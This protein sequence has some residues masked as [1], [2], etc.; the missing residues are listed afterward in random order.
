MLLRRTTGWALVTASV[1]ASPRALAANLDAQPMAGQKLRVDGMLS[2][3]RGR[4]TELGE[5]VQGRPGKGL[6]ASGMVGYD[7]RHV[8]VAMK[9]RDANL[10]RTKDAGKSEDHA[11]LLLSI[12]TGRGHATYAVDLFPGEPGRLPGAVKMAGRAVQGA[13]LVEAPAAG[14]FVFEAQ[15][16]WSAFPEAKTV[17]VGL[18]GALR[19]TDA[20]ASGRVTAVVATS[21]A[22]G[23]RSLPPLPLE[24]EQALEATLVQGKGLSAKPAKEL[25]GNV[26]GDAMLERVALY[27]G[28]LTIVGP[29]YRGGKQFYFSD[30]GVRN[31]SMVPRFELHDF[32]GD[33]RDEIVLQKRVG[34]SEQYREILQI[35]KVGTDDAPFV[36]FTH[37]TGIKTTDEQITNVVKIKKQGK[38]TV[39]KISQGQVEGV[40][41]ATY[42]ELKP[43]EYESALL[44]WD[45][46]KSRTFGWDKDAIRKLDEESWE[47]KLGPPGAG[48]K[49]GPG[50]PMGPPKP[51]PPRPPSADEL[52]DRVYAL[53]KKDR[54]VRGGKP[55]F[56]FVT[57]VVG[58]RQNERVLVHGKDIVAFGAGFKGGTSYTFITVGVNEPGDIVD[59]TARDLTGDGKAEVVVRGIVRAKASEELGGMEVQRYA[60][61]V[62]KVTDTGLRRIFG[63]ETGRS[64]DG[65]RVLGAVAF[66]PSAAGLAIELRPA[67]AVGWTQKTYPFPTDTTAAGGLEPLL[68]PWGSERARRYRFDGNGYVA[69]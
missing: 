30:L 1:I 66:Q 54:G 52:L 3:W 35:F 32:D 60:L 68:L 27:D 2:E 58:D 42:D 38:R 63:A 15:I 33:G 29:R 21:R 22:A 44:P 55:S 25:V 40:D 31:A 39:I 49:P 13:K 41:P 50:A 6:S 56:D 5:T 28:H 10:M 62:Y 12:P 8:Y 65:N 26:A 16:P 14:G 61:L 47:P 53:Y 23:G 19:Y 37:E 24:S 7:D 43:G 69:D 9:V 11:T 45:S 67:R 57:D 46:V 34:T 51:P 17:R 64:L 4:M 18:R 20:D 48:A 59:V 36:A